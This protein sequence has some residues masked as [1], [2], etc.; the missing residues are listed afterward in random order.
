MYK[1]Y[2]YLE[3]TIYENLTET[4]MRFIYTCLTQGG[5]RKPEQIKIVKEG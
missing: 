2:D 3:G 4:Q 5:G 1:L